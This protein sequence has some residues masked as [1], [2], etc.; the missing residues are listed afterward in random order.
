MLARNE[1]IEGAVHTIKSIETHFNKW[2]HYP[3]I[4]LNEQPFDDSFIDRINKVVS[5]PVNFGTIP[6]E[7][8]GFPTGMDEARAKAS[9]KK[10][11]DRGIK[12]GG[13]ESYHHMCRFFAG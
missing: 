6:P 2:F 1:D 7:M 4:M 5:G 12:Y 11:G 10:Q 13:L 9:M 3:Y 8:W